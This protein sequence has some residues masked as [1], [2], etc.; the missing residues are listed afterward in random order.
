M[1]KKNISILIVANC[2]WYVYNFRLDLIKLLKNEGY[3]I[4][5]I[6]PTDEYKNLV[7]E[8]VDEIKEWNLT[9]GSI[10]PFLE[11]RSILQLIYLYKKFSP[12]L[13]HNFTI[14]P[15]LYGGLAGR[16]IRQRKIISHITG[17]GPSFFGY[18]K[19]I[20]ILSYIL[21]PIYKFSFQK[22]AKIIF[23]NE[24]DKDIFLAK[25][26]CKAESSYII[27]GSGVDTQKFKNNK[28]KKEYFKPIQILFPARIIRE[29]GFT[30][31]FETCLILWEE[32]YVFKLNIAGEIDLENKSTLTR[33]EII[34]ISINKNVN[35][36]GKVLDMK[37]IY[38]KTDIVVLPSW[39]EGLSKSLIEASSMSLPIITTDVPGCKEII[40]NER[41][42]I[43][44]PLKNK[45]LLKKAIKELIQNPQLGIN[46][47]K[48]AREIVKNKFE[49]SYINK[50]IIDLYK[51]VLS[52]T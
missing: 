1:V 30:E 25:K 42:G 11:I 39:R 19:A 33:K 17:I 9:R 7:K 37:K 51:R 43:I 36:H 14:K 32:G 22:N 8:Y 24:S 52:Q 31:L 4:I 5:V 41:S 18:S 13:I 16:I 10:N 20:R 44:V 2:F 3:K 46:Y 49:A 26:I 34:D 40:E 27:Q 12:N 21:K 28:I 29:K 50:K 48:K 6:A 23:H 47:G 15:C 45:F 38:S 35:F